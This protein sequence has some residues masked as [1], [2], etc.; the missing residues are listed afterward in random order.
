MPNTQVPAGWQGSMKILQN[1]GLNDLKALCARVSSAVTVDSAITPL[2]GPLTSSTALS[3]YYRIIDQANYPSTPT[4]LDAGDSIEILLSS[5]NVNY[6]T[7]FLLDMNNHNPS[8][9]FVKK[10]VYLSQFAGNNVNF[11]VRCHYGTGASFFVDID[12]VVVKNEAQTAIEDLNRDISFSIYPNPAGSQFA[13]RGSQF[14]TG[15]ETP[16]NVYDISGREI[17]SGSFTVNRHVST[18]N[19]S[20][21]LYFVQ[22]GNLIRKLIV[23]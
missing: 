9:N 12:T 15:E 17:Y 4:N 3:F 6:Q 5:D 11:K 8:F 22:I 10:K 21:G 7:V 19:W 2:I 23:E 13:V 16:L 14:T 1:H 18:V 20:T